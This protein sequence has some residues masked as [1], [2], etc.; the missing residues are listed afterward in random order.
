MKFEEWW[1]KHPLS[2]PI[3]SEM[4][5]VEFSQDGIKE[6]ARQ[7]WDAAKKIEEW[8]LN[9]VWN[10]IHN[11]KCPDCDGRV[12]YNNELKLWSC[13]CGSL[14]KVEHVKAN[15]GILKRCLQK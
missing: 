9:D 11:L 10:D 3:I 6:I 8:T 4:K 1:K 5:F 2:G 14:F 13:L 15:K 12:R 7:A